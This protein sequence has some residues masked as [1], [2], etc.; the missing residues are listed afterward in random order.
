MRAT[1]K[2]DAIVIGSGAGG[3]ITALELARS[4]RRV[5]VLE[6]GARVPLEA[7]GAASYE[8]M[9]QFYRRGGMTPLLGPVPI[10]FVEGAC[11]GGSTEINSGFWHRT[12]PE[13]I[14]RWK[15]Q[16][17]VADLSPR[18]LEPHFDL[19]EEL[20]GVGE[21]VGPE[22]PST[23]VLREGV[24]A[25]GW[26]AQR[27][28]RVAPGC[29]NTNA[30]ASGCPTGAKRSVA[31]TIVP[32]AE[33]AG[34]QF[35]PNAR[36]KLLLLRNRRVTGVLVEL[37]VDGRLELVRLDADQVFVCGGT[38]ETPALLLRSGI[39][40]AVGN[41]LRIHP[42]L[43]VAARFPEH[44]DAQS[45]VLPLVQVREFWPEINL[46]GSFFSP[47]HLAMLLSEDR[48]FLGQLPQYRKMANY[49]VAVRGTGSGSVRSTLWDDAPT[50][51]Y[52]LSD[53]DLR[54]LS[55][56]LA[57]LAMLLLAAGAEVVYPGVAG[58]GEIRSPEVA[59]RWLDELLPRSALSL[60]TV[61]AF[62]SCPMG[63]RA[64]RCAVDSFGRVKGH[65]N[66]H[67]NDASMLPDSPGVNPQGTIMAIARRNVLRF[68]EETA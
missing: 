41:T 28:K 19:V 40:H 22:P 7:Y 24:E 9:D 44:I 48:A 10:G 15:A 25:M 46:G 11:V 2:V 3:S 54:N 49:Y 53:E 61:H 47:G 30:C 43:K 42:M 51:W 5:V 16:F 39:R 64:G 63:E 12:P 21:W 50:A 4:G 26:A 57:R 23:R 60:S 32:L 8:A 45:S 35:I 52:R 68:I 38:T 29:K 17:D 36:A 33:R 67:I 37:T 20:L 66:L 65:E 31:T 6:E 27:M 13:A 18:D 1:R 59:A 62:S 58:L 56:G 55:R 34:A 14:L